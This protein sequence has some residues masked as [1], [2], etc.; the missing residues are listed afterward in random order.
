[1]ITDGTIQKSKLGFQIVDTD[2]NGMI[3]IT[4]VKDGSGGNFGVSYTTF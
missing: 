4:D 2:E 1:M 3:S